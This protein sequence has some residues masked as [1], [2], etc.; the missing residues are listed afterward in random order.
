MV[1]RYR[2]GIW[3]WD[4]ATAVL[5][6]TVS[7]D[8]DDTASTFLGFTSDGK[9][10][11]MARKRIKG[12]SIP[13]FIDVRECET[14]ELRSSLADNKWD[15][16]PQYV[17]WSNDGRTFVATSGHKYKGRVWDVSTGKLKATF[18]MV[19]TYSRIPFDFGFKD[20]DELSLHPTLPL[21]SATSN[22]LVR[23]WNSETGEL[24]QTLENTGELGEWSADGKM[25][26]TS[27]K[28]RMWVSVWDV[29]GPEST[30]P[31]SVTATVSTRDKL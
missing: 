31:R 7:L 17:F 22:K 2:C 25:F 1:H 4:S 27:T 6:H 24:M 28:D 8:K 26:L 15:D 5:K 16:W 9:M 3:I 23:L 18:P 29:V 20:R 11:A 14:G 21:I 13:T 12:W 30:R 10:F 19:L